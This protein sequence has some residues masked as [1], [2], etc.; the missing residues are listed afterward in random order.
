[1]AVTMKSNIIIPEVMEASIS[2]KLPNAI[3]FAPLSLMTNTLAGKP[4]DTLSMPKYAYAGDAAIVPEGEAIPVEA[5]TQSKTTATVKKAAKAIGVTDEALGA[6]MDVLNE[7]E[8]QIVMAVASKIDADCIAA[9]GTV[10]P[11]MSITLETDI[12]AAGVSAALVKF[13]EEIEGPKVLFV[14]PAQ[15]HILRNE[16][17]AIPASSQIIYD[18]AIGMLM[19]CQVVI[20]ARLPQNTNFIVKP[21]AVRI[22]TKK[23]VEIE[24]DREALK[25]T[26][27][28]IADQHYVAFLY[29]ES[30]A[31]KVTVTPTP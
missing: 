5:L 31:V 12:S 7:I 26:T 30:K 25:K 19:G 14:T 15:A 1:M 10:K 8:S 16:L 17:V 28:V 6:G 20:T 29:D 9:L 11:N 27:N 21:G 13:G 24:T 3:K 4:G 23:A 22:E 2:A 18:G